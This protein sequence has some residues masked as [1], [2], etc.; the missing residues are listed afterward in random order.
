MTLNDINNKKLIATQEQLLNME[1]LAN[2]ITQLE[3]AYGQEFVVT[4]GLRTE[5]MQSKINPNRMKSAHLTGQA[6]D[7]LDLEKDV[8]RWLIDNIKLVRQLKLCLE[9]KSFTERWVHIQSKPTK[10]GNI[11]FVP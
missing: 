3:T 5:A 1:H 8:W 10:Y 9:D 4:S 2:C 11:V 7:I 6:V